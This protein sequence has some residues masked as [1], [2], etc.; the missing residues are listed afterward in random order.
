MDEEN[1]FQGC[2]LDV[3]ANYIFNMDH[4]HQLQENKFVCKKLKY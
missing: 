1:D 2:V 4:W 3:D